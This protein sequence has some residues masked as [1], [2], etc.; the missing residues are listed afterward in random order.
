MFMVI[1]SYINTD[2]NIKSVKKKFFQI[3]YPCLSINVLLS[4]DL[5]KETLEIG[6]V[7]VINQ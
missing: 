2:V 5:E 6:D 1:G 3:F 4:L 7:F